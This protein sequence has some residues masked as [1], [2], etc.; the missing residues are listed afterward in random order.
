[1]GFKDVLMRA[2]AARSR[3]EAPAP[4][5]SCRWATAAGGCCQIECTHP[6]GE[7]TRHHK[8]HCCP[9]KCSLYEPPPDEGANNPAAFSGTGVVIMPVRN[10]G[11]WPMKTIESFRASKAPG[12]DLRFVVIDEANKG[13]S[14]QDL[15]RE[16]DVIYLS[17]LTEPTGQGIA[18][19]RAVF[20]TRGL[21]PRAYLSIDAHMD[22]RTQ[23]GAERLWLSAEQTGGLVQA[24]SGVI[25]KQTDLRWKGCKWAVQHKPALV[26]P[27]T[28]HDFDLTGGPLKPIDIMAG[29]CYAFTPAT[30]DMLG[31][32]AECF[33]YYGWYERD[34]AVNCRFQGIP[35]HCDNRVMC[36]HHYRK[37]RP[38][39]MGGVWRVRGYVQSF[40]KMFRP[41]IW[42]R[43]WLPWALA[44]QTK[45]HDPIIDYLIHA[46]WILDL[47]AAFEGRKVVTDEEVLDWMGV[48]LGRLPP[49]E[50]AP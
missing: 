12:T 46:P 34:L 1:M 22:M 49:T 8:S 19:S 47:N 4:A 14:V 39:P 5:A 23:F 11:D 28:T 6:K 9:E 18:R 35:Q 50:R 30:F 24:R 38:Y 10:E 40:R 41:D 42:E 7:G 31:G 27:D 20:A 25:A 37:V 43:V 44:V 33:G 48:D 26:R 36:W 45:H 3:K 2:E 15:G 21:K 17:S 13:S 32:F 16:P 29:A